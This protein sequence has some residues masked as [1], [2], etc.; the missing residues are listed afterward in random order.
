[1][2]MNSGLYFG[3]NK[4]YISEKGEII[5]THF[6][7]SGPAVLDISSKLGDL[8]QKGE[9]KIFLDF[10]PY[11]QHHLILNLAYSYFYLLL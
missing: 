9:T 6:G 10:F 7:I 1:M 3:N 2:L 8:L 11:L 4:K 5:F